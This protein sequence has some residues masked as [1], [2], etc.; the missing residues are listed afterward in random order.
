[1]KKLL[2]ILS[3]LFIFTGCGK[4]DAKNGVVN[5]NIVGDVTIGDYKISNVSLVYKNGVSTLK[6]TVS[7]NSN[8]TKTI[9]AF[10]ITF[11][12]KDDIEIIKL[13]T[14][15]SNVSIDAN[16]SLDVSTTT[17]IDLSDAESV[18]YTIE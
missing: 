3:I 10:N 18:V 1:M 4:T 5:N 17:D 14:A 15:L 12:T 11:K 6:V 13:D 2:V 7:N 8:E 16:S 9:K